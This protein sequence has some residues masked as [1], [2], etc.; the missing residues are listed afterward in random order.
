M[1]RFSGPD[2]PD[3][4][5]FRTPHSCDN[6]II[7]EIF[8]NEIDFSLKF[9]EEWRPAGPCLSYHSALLEKSKWFSLFFG[10]KGIGK[11]ERFSEE[12]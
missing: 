5:S 7:T 9:S 6:T 12:L 10:W 11:L 2:F 1:Y 4:Q 3:S 8:Q